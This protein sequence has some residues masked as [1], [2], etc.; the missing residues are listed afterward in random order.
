[1]KELKLKKECVVQTHD[2]SETFVLQ[3]N[4]NIV[5]YH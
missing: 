3:E 4:Q 5:N 1:M 2:G